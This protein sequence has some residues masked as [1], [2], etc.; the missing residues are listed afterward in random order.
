LFFIYTDTL[1][2]TSLHDLILLLL[3]DHL[4]VPVE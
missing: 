3:V 4:A 1:P 2:Q